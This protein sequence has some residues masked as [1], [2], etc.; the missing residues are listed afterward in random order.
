[1]IMLPAQIA[2]AG[3]HTWDIVEVFSNADGTV[4]FIELR[5]MNGTPGETA[6]NGKKV[7]SEST[8]NEYTFPAN[9]VAPTTNKRI[10]LGTTAFA[11]LAGAPTP[12]HIIPAGFFDPAGDTL[13]YH[14]YDTWVI[15]AGT[16]PLDC[17]NSLN[18]G[19][20]AA[21]NSPTNYAG[22]AGSV[23]CSDAPDCPADLTNSKGTEPDGAVNVFD[24]LALLSNWNTD[25]LGA[26]IAAP[27]N[28][29]DVFD[30]VG[31]LEA[32]NSCE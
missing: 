32:W 19:I 27:T 24:L 5:E 4:Q 29:V 14:V 3:S 6:L 28:I 10:L 1:M 25:G 26:A 8:G 2:L 23:D 20:G 21:V 30:L 22:T 17:I 12:D 18:D 11:A 31:L 13:R 15:A 9:A 7:T 16:V